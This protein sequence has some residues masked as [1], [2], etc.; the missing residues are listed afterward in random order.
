MPWWGWIAM[1]AIL[2]GAEMAVVDAEFYLVFLGISAAIVGGLR[3][4]GLT[5]VWWVDWLVFAVLSVATMVTFRQRIYNRLRGGMPSPQD[6]LVGQSIVVEQVLGP[7][8]SGRVE[9]RGTTWTVLNSGSGQIEA[10]QR[11]RIE[12]VDGLTLHVQRSA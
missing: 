2:L 7:G 6:A 4:L 10:G 12:H 8:V 1:G 9:F 3:L 5:Q 11:C